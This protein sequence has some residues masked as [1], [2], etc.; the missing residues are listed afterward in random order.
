MCAEIVSS[1]RSVSLRESCPS[2]VCLGGSRVPAECQR[3]PNGSNDCRCRVPAPWSS[4]IVA[5]SMLLTA[6]ALVSEL[7]LGADGGVSARNCLI[8]AVAATR[9]LALAGE[10][11]YFE[12]RAVP[13]EG[14][15]LQ[16][17]TSADVRVLSARLNP[18]CRCRQSTGTC[19]GRCSRSN[20]RPEKGIQT[21]M[22]RGRYT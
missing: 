9:A 3:Q 21:P 11:R 2:G 14:Q 19:R 12:E 22:A 5:I 16:S 7:V 13:A 15:W 18:S 8:R 4:N 6:A 17:P 1:P 20:L 10:A